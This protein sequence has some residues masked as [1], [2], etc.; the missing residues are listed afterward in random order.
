MESKFC[1]LNPKRPCDLSCRA[2]FQTDD[3]LDPVGCMVLW[4]SQT[5]SEAAE[6]IREAL[7]SRSSAGDGGGEGGG[8]DPALN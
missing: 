4:L 2:A 3:A 8:K 5:A 1:F 6:A 7:D